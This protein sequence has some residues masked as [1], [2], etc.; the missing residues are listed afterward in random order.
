MVVLPILSDYDSPD[1]TV[2]YRRLQ[3]TLAA[4]LKPI[5][6]PWD[7]YQTLSMKANV[8]RLVLSAI[9]IKDLVLGYADF[10]KLFT[11]HFQNYL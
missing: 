6:F 9:Q 11:L 5:C 1:S 7:V 4:A 3:T 10:H 2:P 8:H